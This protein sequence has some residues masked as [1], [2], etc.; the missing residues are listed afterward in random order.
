MFIGLAPAVGYSHLVHSEEH[1]V[2]RHERV[3]GLGQDAHEHVLVE[4]V[5]RDQG[6]EPADELGDHSEL[7]EVGG[8]DLEQTA[9]SR[10]SSI[11]QWS[12]VLLPGPAAT[13]SILGS[14]KILLI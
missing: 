4:R 1:L 8:L 2:L 13:R 10:G 14:P 5:E 6:R 9:M 11:A 3:P 7:D 12:A